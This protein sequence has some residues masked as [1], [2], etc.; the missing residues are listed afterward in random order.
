MHLV[1]HTTNRGDIVEVVNT[2][3]S[4]LPGAD[5]L[6]DWTFHGSTDG[7]ETQA[8]DQVSALNLR[9]RRLLLTTNSDENAMAAPASIGFSR[10]AAANGSAAM[11][12]ANAQ[13]KLP[14]M[15][16]NVLRASRIASGA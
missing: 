15:V 9:S 3:G 12:Y 14:L 11:L 1:L 16:A 6:G 10:P 13:N 8:S 5:G 7:P 4:T 2:V